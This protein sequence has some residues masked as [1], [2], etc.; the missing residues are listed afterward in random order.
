MNLLNMCSRLPLHQTQLLLENPLLLN[1]FP[2]SLELRYH[3]QL[4]KYDVTYVYPLF[5]NVNNPIVS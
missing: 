5:T 2:P 3:L 1:T 4:I